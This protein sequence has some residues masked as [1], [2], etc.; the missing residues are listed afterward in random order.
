MKEA[1]IAEA[2]RS[3]HAA[4]LGSVL[5]L[6]A[7]GIPSNA[8]SGSKMSIKIAAGIME[9]LGQEARGARLAGQMSG[10]KFE[11]ICGGFLKE[12]FPRLQHLRPGSWKVISR[13]TVTIADF[14]QYQHLA[15]LSL[16]ASGNR[17]LSA[18]L[19]SDYIIK[20]DVVVVRMP[21]E[22]A[23]INSAG[24]LVDKG[25]SARL[26][27]LRKANNSK[28]ILH[29]S[30]SCKWTLRSDRAQNARSEGL[31]LVR[32]RKGR[33]P[34]IAVV[35]GEPAP[36]RIVSIALGTGDIDCVYH[37]ALPEL[38][39]TVKEIGNED[40]EELLRTMIEGK[41]LRDISDLALDLA[42]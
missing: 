11:E 25:G 7:D 13:E 26:T 27:P 6:D 33:L 32:N 40:A 18:A 20:P 16:L 17:E 22:D 30:I 34:H 10:A 19:G 36:N 4:L 1:F 24:K 3:F 31:V 8:D 35:V 37:F 2:R 9:R 41:R 21:E 14:D 5:K 15:A 29:A 12:V 28:P 23:V 38:I 39:A 42:I